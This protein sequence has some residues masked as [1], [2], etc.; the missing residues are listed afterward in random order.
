[1]DSILVTKAESVI[2][3]DIFRR[4]CNIPLVDK[5]EAYQKLDDNWQIIEAD[6]EMI[7][8][9][10]K[11]AITQ[12]DA[13]MVIKKKGNKETEVQDGYV[14]HILPFTLVQE[15]LLVEEIKEITKL[16]N[17]LNAILLEYEEIIESIA[18]EDRGDFLTEDNTAF[19]PKEVAKEIKA[20]GKQKPEAGSIEEKL[21]CVDTLITKEKNIK[22]SIKQKTAELHIKT[23]ETIEALSF[24]DALKLLFKK[25]ISPIVSEIS[26]MPDYVVS[27]LESKINK[28][29]KKYSVTM[30]DIESEIEKSE[31][32][33]S[34]MI[35][36]LDGDEFDMSGLKELQ[37]M[38]KG[39]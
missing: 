33:F 31:K 15:A 26:I 37:K 24:D 39:E 9:E 28:L 6:L 23:K 2:A 32:E 18:E 12:V 8:T 16:E 21:I 35:D 13:N 19:V 29:T 38:L 17:Q 27:S 36:Q 10:G 30:L 7:K 20:I 25:W 4:L 3:D 34:N 14:G 5:Y 22:K 1:M 11:E